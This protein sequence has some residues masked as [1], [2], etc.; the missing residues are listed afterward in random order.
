MSK[1][2]TTT[3]K[4]LPLITPGEILQ[5]EFMA[6][7]GLSANAL[8]LELHVPA[9]RILAIVKGKRAI[10]ADTALRLAQYFGNSPEFWLNLQKNFELDS[11]KR[12]KLGEIQSQV[13][14]HR[15]SRSGYPASFREH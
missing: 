13:S 5:E 7:L 1:L 3:R 14:R 12:E 11:T 15:V 9:N 8:A 4:L 10:T 2:S 6:P